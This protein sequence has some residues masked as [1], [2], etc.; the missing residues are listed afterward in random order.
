ML[1][2][3]YLSPTFQVPYNEVLEFNIHDDLKLNVEPNYKLPNYEKLGAS[4]F[5]R[6]LRDRVDPNIR[7]PITLDFCTEARARKPAAERLDENRLKC[8]KDYA[9]PKTK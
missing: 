6:D 1:I 5:M 9:D 2:L 4:A 3:S 7:V 8:R